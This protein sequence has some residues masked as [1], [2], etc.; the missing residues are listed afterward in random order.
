MAALIQPRPTPRREGDVF[1]RRIAAGAVIHQGGMVAL[2]AAG[3]AV[4]ASADATLKTDGMALQSAG[5]RFPDVDTVEVRR[6]VYRFGNSA[7]ADAIGRADIGEPAFVVD[8]QTVAAGSAG[9]TRPEAGTIED[10]DDQ[11]VWVRFS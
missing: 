6:S 10:V 5:G 1:A 9:G 3:F 2:D 8:D 7:G 11:G 4:A